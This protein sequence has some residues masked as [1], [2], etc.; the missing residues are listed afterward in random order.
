MQHGQARRPMQA[1]GTAGPQYDLGSPGGDEGP[2]AS[3]AISHGNCVKC[4]RVP[5]LVGAS[6]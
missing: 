4:M 1:S 3:L 5:M 2:Y 6:K